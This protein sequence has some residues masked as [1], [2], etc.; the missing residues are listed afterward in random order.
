MAGDARRHLDLVAVLMR[1]D[2]EILDQLVAAVFDAKFDGFESPVVTLPCIIG[3]HGTLA[4]PDPVKG[5]V[6]L[7]HA[8]R[9]GSG[10]AGSTQSDPRLIAAERWGKQVHIQYPP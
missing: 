5:L 4:A 7:Q 10:G 8:P 6:S 3:F 9:R 2:A 1:F